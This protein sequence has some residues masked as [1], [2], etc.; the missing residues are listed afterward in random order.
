M[1]LYNSIQEFSSKITQNEAFRI[2]KKTLALYLAAKHLI[3]HFL[4]VF[5][6]CS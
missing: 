1:I 5:S 3:V 2:E 6:E 4:F